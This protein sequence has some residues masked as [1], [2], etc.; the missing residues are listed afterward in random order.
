MSHLA[1]RAGLEERTRTS[2]MTTATIQNKTISRKPSPSTNPR[3]IGLC[4][5]NAPTNNAREEPPGGTQSFC[6]HVFIYNC[7]W[8]TGHDHKKK[9]CFTFHLVL[10]QLKDLLSPPDMKSFIWQKSML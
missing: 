9:E 8:L 1:Q 4:A 10:A 2:A 3:K 7:A 6:R 5:T